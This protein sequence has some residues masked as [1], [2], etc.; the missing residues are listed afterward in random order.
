MNLRPPGYELRSISPSAGAQHF[1][2]IFETEMDK[3]RRSCSLRSTAVLRKMGQRLGQASTEKSCF[4]KERRPLLHDLAAPGLDDP[5]DI[6][7]DTIWN[8]RVVVAQQ[9]FPRL[10]H[11]HLCRVGRRCALCH[12]DMDR[13]QRVALIGPEVYPI[14]A[15]F[16]K[17]EACSKPP[18][19]ANSRIRWAVD[20]ITSWYRAISSGVKPDMSSQRYE[21]RKQE[22]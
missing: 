18:C 13:L 8:L 10:C 20:S 19:C 1:S 22:A 15:D 3:T 14:R 17:L 16:K 9:P 12:M 6:P 5:Q 7:Q 4:S 11:P 21:G 2:A